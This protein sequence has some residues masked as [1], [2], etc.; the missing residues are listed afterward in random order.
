[1]QRIS[2]V[3]TLGSLGVLALTFG[4]ACGGDPE[5]GATVSDSNSNSNSDPSTSEADD[6]ASA[7]ANISATPGGGTEPTTGDGGSASESATVATTQDTTT[8]VDPGTTE[9]GTTT[10][11]PTNDTSTT[12]PD[13]S[14]G[15]TTVD[16]SDGT[17]TDDSTTGNQMEECQAPAEQPPCD[18]AGDDPFKAL[19]LNCSN[20]LNKA[21]PIK[22]PMVMAPDK[23][24]F[25]IATRF[26]NA[27]DPMDNKLPA[28]GPKEGSRFLAIGT[29]KFPALK[30]DGALIETDNGDS[31]SNSNPDDLTN[32]PGIMKYQPGS[33]NGQG[34]TP[35]MNCD[36]VNDC[37]DTLDPQWNLFGDNVANDV[38]YMSFDLTV[39]QGTHG[40]M[41]DFAYFSEEWPV[42][43]D[44]IFNDMFVVWSTSETF[45]GNVTF[46]EGKPLT[47]T[48]LDPYMSIQ[49]GD[50]LLAG[51][52]FPGD[53]EGAATGWFTAKASAQPGETFTI[54][55]SVFDMGDT[56][57]DT[58]GILDNFRWD[59]K[60][61]VPTEVDDCGIVPL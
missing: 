24:S 33:N 26:G 25:R 58:V 30:A 31:E 39:P 35:F 36:G 10:V 32:L 60:G 51:T 15:T 59:C 37:S 21:I 19:G 49:P 55:V 8:A 57:W 54:A 16:P 40:Y 4:A 48:A 7:T 22:N 14:E 44:D 41:F 12:G 42:Y 3:T 61:C 29:G 43:V 9:P 28:W 27:Q 52:G 38:F 5:P 53:D 17:T 2:L 11:D 47:V 13:P 18:E 34:G 6:D 50:P 20:D 46:I 23:T 1:M 56:V 45:T